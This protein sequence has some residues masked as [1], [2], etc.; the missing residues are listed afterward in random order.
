[1]INNGLSG[2]FAK[3][4]A[5]TLYI[6]SGLKNVEDRERSYRNPMEA[7]NKSNRLPNEVVDILHKTVTKYAAP[8][9]KRYYRLKARH[10]EL[11]KL[12]W[13]DRNAPLPFSDTAHYIFSDALDIVLKAYRSFSPT[14]A[15]I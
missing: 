4:S 1:M 13:S 9:A 14:L 5:Q 3:Y 10:L 12:K 6:V 8:L 15:E 2:S 7:R 11:K